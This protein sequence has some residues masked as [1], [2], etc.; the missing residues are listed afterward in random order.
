LDR[1]LRDRTGQ[2]LTE[3]ILIIV[4][5]AIL[6]YFSVQM[7]GGKVGE[8]ARRAGDAVTNGSC[9]TGHPPYPGSSG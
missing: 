1:F 9:C 2:G 6:A 3:Y 5:I 8:A 7:F 4:V